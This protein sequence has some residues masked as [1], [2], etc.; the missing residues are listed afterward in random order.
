MSPVVDGE[1]GKKVPVKGTW[2]A[3]KSTR[4]RKALDVC[5]P[6]F[7]ML[8]WINL[9]FSYFVLSER[10]V[11]LV[12]QSWD[13]CEWRRGDQGCYKRES[14][15]FRQATWRPREEL[16]LHFWFKGNLKTEFLLP[17]NTSCFLP[18][19]FHSWLDEVLPY[20]GWSYALLKSTDMNANH[21]KK[22][23]KVW[24]QNPD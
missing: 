3:Q 4:W 18:E 9:A 12:Q 17:P 14:V 22:K 23:K 2:V 11:V 21:I 8:L 24:Q 15:I 20:Y 7:S 19:G 6:F 5:S 10:N 16:V 13:R 1:G